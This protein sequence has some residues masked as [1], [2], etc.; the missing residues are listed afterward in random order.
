[1]KRTLFFLFL[2]VLFS[3]NFAVS[4]DSTAHDSSAVVKKLRRDLILPDDPRAVH[5]RILTEYA[6]AQAEAAMRSTDIQAMIQSQVAESL[7]ELSEQ[8]PEALSQIGPA[9]EQ[10]GPALE[11]V[12]PALEQAMQGLELGMQELQNVDWP[13][14]QVE[15]ADLPAHFADFPP[16][17]DIPPLPPLPPMAP[18]P[19]L[20]DAPLPPL[21]GDI[22]GWGFAFEEYAENLSDDEQ[23]RIQALA[24]LMSQDEIAA[25][26]EIKRL[27][28]EHENWAM[29]AAAVSLLASSESA[30]SLKIF[31]EVLRYDADHRVRRAV[32]RALANRPEAEAREILKRLLQK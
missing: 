14:I 8:L 20:P 26:P 9:L 28:R 25:L 32:V 31:D 16:V 1:M 27:C 17:P 30:E 21:H 23:V 13:E 15:L 5:A 11:Q 22:P 12:G 19:P 24:A 29:R 4:Q 7:E 6:K 3:S 2:L 10:I 18:I